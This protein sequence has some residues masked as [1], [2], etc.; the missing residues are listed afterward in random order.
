MLATIER[1]LFL[2]SVELFHHVPDEVLV[3]VAQTAR[4]VEFVAGERF[5]VQGDTGDSLY[6][7]IDGSV[8]IVLD[9][10]GTIATRGPK[11]VLGEMAILSSQPRTASCVAATPCYTLQIAREEFLHLLTETP[12]LA[13]GIIEELVRRIDDLSRRVTP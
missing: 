8:D 1:V 4:E 13:L 12:E 2:R 7:V 11:S 10:K 5:I 9:G 3:W 6:V